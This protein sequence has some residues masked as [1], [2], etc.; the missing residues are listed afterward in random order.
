M[1]LKFLLCI[2]YSATQV[3]YIS[4]LRQVVGRDG[5]D[6]RS[7]TLKLSKLA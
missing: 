7:G 1:K 4:G 3:I 2:N 5:E 6:N